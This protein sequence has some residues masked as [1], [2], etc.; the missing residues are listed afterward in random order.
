MKHQ[1]THRVIYQDTDA[2]GVVYYANYLGLFERGRTE[3]LRQMALSV[4]EFKEKQGILFAV[5]KVDCD[6]HAPA[7][8]DDELTVTTEITATTPARVTFTQQIIKGE[9]ALVSARITLCALS[10]KDFRPVRLPD[11]LK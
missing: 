4:K 2:E 8:Y 7:G 10:V 9:K 6:Y 3:L 5:T 11:Q 1:F